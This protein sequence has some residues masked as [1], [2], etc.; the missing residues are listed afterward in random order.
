[1]FVEDGNLCNKLDIDGDLAVDW[2]VGEPQSHK[3]GYF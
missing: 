3:R 2:V 1:M